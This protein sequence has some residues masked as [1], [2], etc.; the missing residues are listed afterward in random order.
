MLIGVCVCDNKSF[1]K[2]FYVFLLIVDNLMNGKLRSGQL[3]L[4]AF[5]NIEKF[6]KIVRNKLNIIQNQREANY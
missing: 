1:L 4:N 5:L 6:N 2:T 3:I